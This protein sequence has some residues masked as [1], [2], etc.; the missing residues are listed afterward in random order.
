MQIIFTYLAC[1]VSFLFGLFFS[2]W[3][4]RVFEKSRAEKDEPVE[5]NHQE[6]VAYQNR[7]SVLGEWLDGEPRRR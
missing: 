1:L 4:R 2:A 7:H 6:L 3:Y 5:G